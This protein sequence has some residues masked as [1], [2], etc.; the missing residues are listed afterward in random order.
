MGGAGQRPY[1]LAM[2]W[3]AMLIAATIGS[4]SVTRA[5]STEATPP[6]D[7]PSDVGACLDRARA[8][9]ADSEVELSR[10]ESELEGFADDDGCRD[11]DPEAPFRAFEG[12]WRGDW[13]GM[14]VDHVWRTV[15]DGVQ[16]VLIEDGGVRKPGINLAHEGTICGIVI[17][18]EGQERLHSGRFVAS[19]EAPAYVEWRTEHS[20]YR[21]RVTC[22]DGQRRYEIEERLRRG[23]VGVRA[24]YAPPRP[25][26][27][28]APQL[29][30]GGA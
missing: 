30:R 27:A 4:L 14:P 5:C 12:R 6:P 24:I 18:A 16:L 7:E 9:L 11:M 1:P 21:E 2:T 8:R 23:G 20:I 17:D 10:L 13:N 22:R 19:G 26:A 29:A 28:P 15:A 25:G 3:N